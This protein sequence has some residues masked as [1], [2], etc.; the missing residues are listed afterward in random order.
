VKKNENPKENLSKGVSPLWGVGGSRIDK[1]LWA[2]RLFK[3]R[4]QAADACS[5]NYVFIEG[6]PVKPSRIIKPGQLIEI[7]R[8]GLTRKIEVLSLLEKRVSAKLVADYYKDR[9]PKEEIEAYKARVAKAA[10]YRQPGTGR[11]TKKERR[12]MDD[13]LSDLDDLI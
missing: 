13:F 2:V 3:T 8:A 10:A 12:S 6:H 4:T 5:S 7:K 9:T 1:W 11:P